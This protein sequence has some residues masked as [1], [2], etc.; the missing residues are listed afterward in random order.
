[1]IYEIN[2][3]A[4]LQLTILTWINTQVYH[5]VLHVINA[6]VAKGGWVPRSQGAGTAEPN[7]GR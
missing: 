7:P 3:M 6:Y 2:V 4:Y 1:M 5:G